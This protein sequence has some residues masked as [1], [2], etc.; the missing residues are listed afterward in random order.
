MRRVNLLRAH[1]SP[2]GYRYTQWRCRCPACVGQQHER[3]RFYRAQNPEA[4]REYTRRYRARNPER[5]REMA[6]AASRARRERDPEHRERYR[7][8]NRERINETQRR[9]NTAHREQCHEYSRKWR[10]S[11]RR[12]DRNKH[13]VGKFGIT[14]DEWDARFGQQGGRCAICGAESHGGQGWH[15]D[16]DHGAGTVRGILCHKCNVGLGCFNDDPAR[17]KAAARYLLAAELPLA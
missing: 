1:G 3:S 12:K 13:L 2:T 4:C 15:T 7:A 5:A 17:L 16:H 11:H 10:E 8:A 9:W 14:A 6:A